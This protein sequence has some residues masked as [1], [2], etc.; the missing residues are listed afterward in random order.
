M[1]R[2]REVRP[3]GRARSANWARKVR[4]NEAMRSAPAINGGALVDQ[5]RWADFTAADGRISR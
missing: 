1:S 3:N 2:H 4:P 5:R